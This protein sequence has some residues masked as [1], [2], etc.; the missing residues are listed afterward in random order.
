MAEVSPVSGVL[1]RFGYGGS[2]V[3]TVLRQAMAY[4]SLRSDFQ[5]PESRLSHSSTPWG[6]GKENVS[7]RYSDER[8]SSPTQA[9]HQ[10][11]VQAVQKQMA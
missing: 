6:I 10:T 1:I 4:L 2:A 11:Y 7:L 3:A 5:D 9:L 8:I